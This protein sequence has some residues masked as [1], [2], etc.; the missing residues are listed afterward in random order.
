MTNQLHNYSSIADIQEFLEHD[1]APKFFDFGDTNDYKI[2]VFG[3][4]NEV[5]STITADIFNVINIAKREFYPATAQNMTSFYKMAGICNVDVPMTIPAS[6]NAILMM[7]EKEIIENSTIENGTYC[8]IL[9]NTMTVMVDQMQ[10]SIDYPIRIMAKFLN[11]SYSY[12][13]YYD[14]SQLNSMHKSSTIYIQNKTTTIGN[15]R[16]LLMQ[17]ELQQY[18]AKSDVQTISKNSELETVSLVFTYDGN[19]AGFDV[20]YTSDPGSA[21]EIY[22]PAV[23]SNEITPSGAYCIYDFLADNKIRLTFPKNPYFSPKVNSEIRTTIYTSSGSK[24]NFDEYLGEI[25]CKPKSEKYPYNNSITIK[26]TAN[27]K[28]SGGEDKKDDER[29]IREIKE[30]FCTNGTITTSSDL[31]IYVNNAIND[32]SIR[33]EFTKARDDVLQRLY[34]SFVLLKDDSNNV[35]PTNTCQLLI[36]RDEFDVFENS[37][38]VIK[39]GKVFEYTADYPNGIIM[40]EHSLSE[41][42]DPYD[43]GTSQKFLFTNPFLICVSTEEGIVGYYGNSISE[44]KQTDFTFVENRSFYQ[45]ICLGIQVERNPI[46]GENFYTF[47]AKISPSSD[48]DPNELIDL[49]IDGKVKEV[50]TI[51]AKHDGRVISREYKET[52]VVT[53]IEYTDVPE[54]EEKT[55]IIQESTYSVV[56]P[57]GTFEYNY[58]YEMQFRVLD[59]FVEGDIIAI[60]KVIDRGRLR[61]AI[62]FNSTLLSN[63]L[64]IPMYIEGYDTEKKVFIL[65]GYIST[66][67]YISLNQTMMLDYGVYNSDGIANDYISIPMENLSCILSIFFKDDTMNFHHDFSSF[68]Y[69]KNYTLTNQ[70]TTSSNNPIDLIKGISFIRSSVV[71]MNTQNLIETV[72]PETGETVTTAPDNYLMRITNVPVVK[73]N[74]IKLSS[75][76]NLLINKIYTTHDALFDAYFKLENQYGIAMIFFNTYGLSKRYRIGNAK[77][78]TDLTRVNCSISIGVELSA[79]TASSIFIEKYRVYIKNVIESLN[80]L[81]ESGKSLYILDLLAESKKSF[82]EIL[83]IEYYGFNDYDHGAQII[84]P[85]SEPS[86]TN[87]IQTYIPEFI[88]IYSYNVNGQLVPKIDIK[89]LNDTALA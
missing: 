72:D 15:E 41:N 81:D 2:G 80:N 22:I 62:D 10:F 39:P 58:G 59:E 27:G 74:W 56:N 6:L 49:D 7:R 55:E 35:I 68:K 50:G 20:F 82:P 73:S 19:L 16:F 88:N 61:A 60:P 63:M 38:G 45:F 3:Y 11:G 65:K 18:M 29:F 71:Y 31:Q 48:I 54:G 89:L 67:D 76:F 17:V 26:G 77:E 32:P 13:T 34:S 14:T 4:I 79:M 12:T 23:S 57:D 75:N 78:M 52:C 46:A 86:T 87:D 37:R 64:Y 24:G 47:T 70:Y 44:I 51:R 42:L 1:I 53:T 33:T 84:V 66:N 43:I 85:K 8:F 83:H 40:S 69:F 5:M 30:N 28:S 21:S 9:D 36:H 25:S